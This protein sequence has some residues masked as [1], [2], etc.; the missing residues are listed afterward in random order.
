LRMKPLS[1]KA[2]DSAA[3]RAGMI[4]LDERLGDAAN[5]ACLLGDISFT[6]QDQTSVSLNVWCGQRRWSP[7]DAAVQVPDT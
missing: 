5:L 7:L 3:R 4:V 1:V 6:S 2:P